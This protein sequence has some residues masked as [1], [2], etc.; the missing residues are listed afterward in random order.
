MTR[1]LPDSAQRIPE[2]LSQNGFSLDLAEF[3]HSTGTAK[4]AAQ[5][6]LYDDTS[7]YRPGLHCRLYRDSCKI[8]KF[9]CASSAPGGTRKNGKFQP[10]CRLSA[11]SWNRDHWRGY[12]LSPLSGEQIPQGGLAFCPWIAV[13]SR[14]GVDKKFC[15]DRTVGVSHPAGGLS[16]YGRLGPAADHRAL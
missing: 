11:D 8:A 2:F 6:R 5:E 13:I 1:S 14:V 3:S 12:P 15:P 4:G 16:S 9:P 7:L 10:G